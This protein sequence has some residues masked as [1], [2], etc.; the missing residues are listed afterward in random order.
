MD[1]RLKNKI[2]CVINLNTFLQFD[3]ITQ[4]EMFKWALF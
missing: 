3:I 4:R 1:S 2:N